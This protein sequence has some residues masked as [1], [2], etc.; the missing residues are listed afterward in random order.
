VNT[1]S[2][3]SGRPGSLSV[4]LL[5]ALLAGCAAAPQPAPPPAEVTVAEP[6]VEAPPAPPPVPTVAWA[7]LAAVEARCQASIARVTELRAAIAAV[8][9]AA[10]TE[11][12]VFEPY[13][14]LGIELSDVGGLMELIANTHPDPG[15]REGA[16]KCERALEALGN[17]VRL[18]R[19]LYEALTVVDAA[20]L[21]PEARR[22]LEKTLLSLRLAG[23]DKDD[24]TRA[25]LKQ[26]H[27]DMVRVGQEFSRNIREDVREVRVAPTELAGLPEDYVKAHP[28]G[29]DG[30]V[31]LNTNYPDYFPAMTYARS[32]ALR[33]ALATAF[34]ARGYPKNDA[35]LKE[36]LRLRHRY[37]TL[38]GF[39]SWAAYQV[40]DK[41]AKR[42]EVVRDFTEQVAR[43]ARPRMKRDLEGLLGRKKKLEKGARSIE[44]WD[45]FFYVQEVQKQKYGFDAAEARAY[46]SYPRVLEGILA[47]YGELFGLTFER[48]ADAPV[49]HPEVAAYQMKA[50]GQPVGR[51]YLD[52]HSRDGKYQHAAMF[53]MQVGLA[54]GQ[55]PE[56]ALV[57]NFANPAQGAALME[58]SQV[59]TF[60]HEFGHL[61]HHLLARRSK[62]V[63]G[64]GISTEWDF[65]EAPSQLLEEWAWSTEVLQRFATHHETGAP[66]PATLVAQ[67]KKASEFGKGLHVM[68]QVFFQSMSW[69]L[70]DRD[71]AQLELVAFTRDLAKKYSPFPYVEGTYIFANFGHLEGYSAV[72]YT[73]QWSLSLAKDIHTRF[74]KAGLLDKA[75]ALD[76]RRLILE[77]GGSR[78][79]AALVAD[80]L[81]RPSNLDAYKAWLERQ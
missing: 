17:E 75:T 73:Y 77:P 7:S 33:Q 48:E 67:M 35:V 60:F 71:P 10:R 76:Y 55:M 58:H 20:A 39:A 32:G 81:G 54:G 13:N 63:T 26:L 5:P 61:I 72:Y 65:V 25:E 80:F 36:L 62:W 22:F 43:L 44:E 37:A 6:K 1:P 70:H 15:L 23:V 24:A 21:D 57:C 19:G 53:P 30:Q 40:E 64:A 8:P 74:E 51:F 14:R 29:A 50:D 38:L 12:T 49:W 3:R 47:L 31:T 79:A 11:A 34:L 27:E 59:V 46:F 68:R 41:M 42:P 16:E 4:L 56:A 66:I 69:Y 78:D 52:M 2:A 9:A 45:R 18:D 28:A